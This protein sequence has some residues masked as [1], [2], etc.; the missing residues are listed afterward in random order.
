MSTKETNYVGQGKTMQ[1][2]WGTKQCLSLNKEKIDQLPVDKY[3]NIK[4]DVMKRKAPDKFN[5]DL[6]VVENTYVP[7]MVSEVNAEDDLQ[8]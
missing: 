8:F 6:S 1:F 4:I 5:N 7:K 3:G 2:D